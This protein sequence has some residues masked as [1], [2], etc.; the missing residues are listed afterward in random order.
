VHVCWGEAEGVFD[1]VGL[2]C[3]VV[4]EGSCSADVGDVFVFFGEHEVGFSFAVCLV[5]PCCFVY[6][7]VFWLWGVMF[8][9]FFPVFLWVLCGRCMGVLCRGRS[10]L[11]RGGR[12]V[13]V[14]GFV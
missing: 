8:C 1:A 13:C 3:A 2:D 9:H 5:E 10:G 14:V 12:R 4:A 11:L 7:C 6:W